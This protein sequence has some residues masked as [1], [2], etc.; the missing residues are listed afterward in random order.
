MALYYLRVEGVNLSNFVYDTQDLSTVRGGSLMLLHAI[1]RVKERISSSDLTTVTKGASSGIFQFEAADDE[2]AESLRNE[3]QDILNETHPAQS[4]IDGLI[5]A[6]FVVSKQPV[7]ADFLSD[8]ET[9]LARNHW[10]QMQQPSL[11]IPAQNGR[12]WSAC[13]IDLVR[14]AVTTIESS[15]PNEEGNKVSASVATRLNYGRRQKQRFYDEQTE[16]RVALNH[17]FARHFNE[18]AWDQ[19]RGNLHQKMAVIYLDGNKFGAIQNDHC[20]DVPNQQKFDQKILGY[21]RDVLAALLQEQVISQPGWVGDI[22][23]DQEDLKGRYRMETL[24][25]GG[26]EL[27]WVVPA[28][29]GWQVLSFFYQQSRDWDFQGIP[30]THAGGMVFCHRNAPISRITNMAIQLA[31]QAKDR[32]KQSGNS[33]QNLFAYQ[34]LESFDHIDSRNLEDFREK[35][36]PHG[37]GLGELVLAGES[38]AEADNALRKLKAQEAFPKGKLHQIVRELLYGSTTAAADTIAGVRNDLK[39]DQKAIDA[40]EKLESCLGPSDAWWV[41]TLELWDYIGLD[42][43][44]RGE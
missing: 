10:Q 19:R 39:A 15:D 22:R 37:C 21:R 33:L 13:D 2:A 44:P 17:E 27:I 31:D 42:P 5:H 9:L 7:S 8:R 26:D 16:Y 35:R 4:G 28:W 20:K 41:H 1:D 25:W 12:D 32:A 18:L 23:Y 30:L 34:V 3:A 14:P 29:H 36:V 6:T 11:A 40:L 38:M 43:I 24:L